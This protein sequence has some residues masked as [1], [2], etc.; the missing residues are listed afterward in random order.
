LEVLVAVSDWTFRDVAASLSN[1]GPIERA[2][3]I[4]DLPVVLRDRSFDAFVFDPCA[5]RADLF[6]G[7]VT[8]AWEC[9]H[10][11]YL[12]PDRS[13]LAMQ[14]L[15]DAALIGIAEVVI[16]DDH[17]RAWSE[18]RHRMFAASPSAAARIFHASAPLVAR[19]PTRIRVEVAALLC[20][21]GIPADVSA[22]ATACATSRRT[23]DRWIR[24]VGFRSAASL[25][26]TARVLRCLALLGRG[27]VPTEAQLADI[28]YAST[29][30]MASELRRVVGSTPRALRLGASGAPL[31]E[32]LTAHLLSAAEAPDT[33]NCLGDGTFARGPYLL[34]ER[35][36][37]ARPSGMR[38]G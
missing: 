33:P 17:G 2:T 16:R 38:I 14:R 22:L 1:L 32:R 11:M 31:V 5:A 18:L 36:L 27:L 29:R 24:D 30:T 35:R 3:R 6:T 8:A 19:L 25:L 10:P 15:I 4:V 37:D 13:N 28:G 9:G 7:I 26:S 20:G 12:I 34:A 21:G 23:L